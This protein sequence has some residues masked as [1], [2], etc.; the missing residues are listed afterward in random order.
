VRVQQRS[1]ELRQLTVEPQRRPK[2]G[3]ITEMTRFIHQMRQT[4][5]LD[6]S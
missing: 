2:A 6:N 3:A 4:S 1:F 5:L